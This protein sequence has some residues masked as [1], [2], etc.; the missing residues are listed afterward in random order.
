V[1]PAAA[2]EPFADDP[3]GA[4][5]V[6]GV[7]HRPAS[8]ARD[9]LVLAHGAGGNRDAPILVAVA[10]AFANAGLLVLRCDLPF[11]QEHPSGPPF[12]ATAARD[13]AG[14]RTAIQAM[15]R[16]APGRTFVGG[17]SYGG[18]QASLL[19]AED[20]AAADGLLL[21][22]YPLHPPRRP[23]E[24]RTA[25]FPKLRVPA[26]FVHG[27][28]DPFGSLAELEAV[29]QLI[30]APTTL[31]VVGGGGHDLAPLHR[32]GASR[33]APEVTAEVVA[34]FGTLVG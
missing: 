20:P 23:E 4:P 25:H 5:A 12:P 29:R 30:P 14:L 26:L 16:L 13:R 24:L 31:T 2:P 9:G 3:P 8:P 27:S 22:S 32:P 6:R 28:R 1:T 18:R 21:L 7:L 10:R 15:R 19:A 11:R 17:H 33:R 34:A